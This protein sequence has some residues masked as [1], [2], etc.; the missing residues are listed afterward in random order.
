MQF[1]KVRPWDE[2]KDKRLFTSLFA[3]AWGCDCDE[4]RIRKLLTNIL[5]GSRCCLDF[6]LEM[7]PLP[8]T[9]SFYRSG[10]VQKIQ[11]LVDLVL[12][13]KLESQQC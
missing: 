4:A 1:F 10:L 13:R 12:S 11:D 5:L 9:S 3:T 2:P 8:E 6:S 7:L